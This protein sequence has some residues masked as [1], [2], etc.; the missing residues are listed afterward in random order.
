MS[1]GFI[2]AYVPRTSNEAPDLVCLAMMIMERASTLPEGYQE[3]ILPPLSEGPFVPFRF[4]YGGGGIVV[5]RACLGNPFN[6]SLY[7]A[8]EQQDATRVRTLDQN[9]FQPLGK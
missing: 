7:M 5:E 8:L 1:Q 2:G 9:P 6:A 3:A 4:V